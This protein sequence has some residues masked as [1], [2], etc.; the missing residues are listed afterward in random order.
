V[1]Y[2]TAPAQPLG[3]GAKSLQT[4]VSP[5]HTTVY[6]EHP[7]RYYYPYPIYSTATPFPEVEFHKFDGTNPKLWI[8]RCETYFDV[9]QTDPSLWVCLASMRMTCSAALWFQTLSN[10]TTTMTWETFVLAVCSRFDKDEHNHLIR[11]FFHSP[12]QTNSHCH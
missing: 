11:H 8:K 3:T 6:P 10:P 12:H 5:I 9:Y 4:K 7:D 2:T 1:V